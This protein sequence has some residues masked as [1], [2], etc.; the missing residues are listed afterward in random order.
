MQDEDDGDGRHNNNDDDDDD[1]SNDGN[2]VRDG[3]DDTKNDDDSDLWR[4]RMMVMAIQM[5]EERKEEAT[6]S[7][8]HQMLCQPVCD[9]CIVSAW[10]NIQMY[11]L[12]QYPWNIF[13]NEYI[14]LGI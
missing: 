8:A 12:P 2:D 3:N 11:L 13:T 9:K 5:Q 1:D 14:G 7:S 10:M 4:T 6:E